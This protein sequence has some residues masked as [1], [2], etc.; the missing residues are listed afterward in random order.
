MLQ[1]HQITRVYLLSP[2]TSE[3]TPNKSTK[4]AAEGHTP[5]LTMFSTALGPY[6]TSTELV[7][8]STANA[9]KIVEPLGTIEIHLFPCD[10]ICLL[11]RG[12]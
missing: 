7:L 1:E 4:G 11:T 12:S 3:I 8:T 9:R 2:I 10:H 6:L 5:L